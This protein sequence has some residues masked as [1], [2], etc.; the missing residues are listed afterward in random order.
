[1]SELTLD[2]TY[3]RKDKDGMVKPIQEW[4]YLQGIAIEPDGDFGTVTERAVNLFQ[5]RVG[6]PVTGAVDAATFE[7]LV[8]PMRNALAPIP[9]DG[10]TVGQMVVAFAEQHLQQ[11]PREVGRQQGRENCGPWVRLYMDGNEGKDW[12]WCAG[13]ACFVLKQACDSLGVAMPVPKSFSSGDLAA[14][15]KAGKRFVKGTGTASDRQNIAPG[16]LFLLRGGTT[17]W[18]HIGIITNPKAGLSD[19]I[20]GNTNDEGSPE[21]YE[22]C[23]RTR[24][25][26]P[27]DFIRI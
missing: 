10:R 19:T 27:I 4:L 15:A 16:Y 24:E 12:P 13:F 7:L 17:G 6:L 9:A 2:R 1:M 11:N 21:G 14:S 20:E 26:G 5:G 22:V 3:K 8:Q 25:Y 18:R 23:M